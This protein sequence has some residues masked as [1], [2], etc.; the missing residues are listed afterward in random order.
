MNTAHTDL[1]IIGGG[2]NGAGI[3]VDAQGRGL[4]VRLVEQNDFASATSSASSK[5]I[6][7]GLRYLEYYEFRLVREA[8][9]ERDVL[10][11]MAP[12]LVKPLRFIL[13]HRPQ[14]RPVWMI[15]AGLFLYDHM[16]GRSVLEKS[17]TLRLEQDSP[18]QSQFKQA[19][20]YTDCWVDDARLVIHNL[21]LLQ[22]LGGQVHNY[23]RCLD[24]KYQDDRW[25]AT[26]QN[27]HTQQIFQV[28]ARVLVNATGPWAQHFLQNNLQRPSP[29]KIR[30]IKG[31]HIIVRQAVS[32]SFSQKFAT[33]E[34]AF[35]LQNDDRRIVFVIPYLQQFTLIGTTDKEYQ[36]DP[37]K[38]AIDAEEITYLLAV[39]NR[40]FKQSLQSSDVLDHYSGVR[41]LC[42]DESNDPSAITRDYTLTLEQVPG[43]LLTVFGGKLTTYRKLAESALKQLQ[44]LF[45]QMRHRWTQHAKLPGGE[46]T[47][48]VFATTLKQQYPWLADILIKRFTTSYGT[49]SSQLLGDAQQLSDLA[50]L[51]SDQPE[52]NPHLLSQRELQYLHEHEWARTPEDILLRR[53]KLGVAASPDL[54]AA[55]KHWLQLRANDKNHQPYA[56]NTAPFAS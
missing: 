34:A 14:L 10:L 9:A 56:G 33:D 12:H 5:L 17:Q 51:L 47:P 30:L 1:L 26:L 38:V 32:P 25:I 46:V 55:V 52:L 18:L 43:G 28:S 6:H 29:R 27:T 23:V 39:Y 13:P 11:R 50:P 20:V 48:M 21:M 15:R 24:A 19:F 35:I 16:G 45:P 42:D 37:A 3:G 53:S 31:S 49:L 8:L 36:G 7:G 22:K 40:H 41:P 4:S 2:I 44:P 54:F